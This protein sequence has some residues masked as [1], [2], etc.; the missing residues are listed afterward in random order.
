MYAVQL[1]ITNRIQVVHRRLGEMIN[2]DTAHKIMLRRYDRSGF[3]RD[4]VALFKH[5]S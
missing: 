5:S 1:V 3:L 4:I 2:I